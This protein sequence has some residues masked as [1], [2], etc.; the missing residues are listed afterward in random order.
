MCFFQNVLRKR[1]TSRWHIMLSAMT[2]YIT[3]S[4]LLSIRDNGSNESHYSFLP[5]LNSTF[6]CNQQD[7]SAHWSEN[8]RE[9]GNPKMFCRIRRFSFS[10]HRYLQRFSLSASV[11]CAE[12]RANVT[13]QQFLRLVSTDTTHRHRCVRLFLRELICVVEESLSETFVSS[14]PSSWKIDSDRQSDGWDCSAHMRTWMNRTDIV[15]FGSHFSHCSCFDAS[16]IGR[17]GLLNIGREKEWLTNVATGEHF[18]SFDA[19]PSRFKRLQWLISTRNVQFDSRDRREE[20]DH[21][22]CIF[23]S[24][25]D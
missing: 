18:E 7:E 24:F 15:L 22:T 16:P 21:L 25:R 12:R 19:L 20:I 9:M 17:I 3:P 5:F 13:L 23:G 1:R 6:E 4:D 8:E 14:D 2:N 11:A 10:L